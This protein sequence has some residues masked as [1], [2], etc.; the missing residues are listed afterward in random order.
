M[1]KLKL[2]Q[3]HKAA[4]VIGYLVTQLQMCDSHMKYHK[5]EVDIDLKELKP[6]L[7][8]NCFDLVTKKLEEQEGHDFVLKVE[9][10]IRNK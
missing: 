7:F 4:Q 10:E 1:F 2:L 9:E 6:Q 8:W 3:D 5:Q